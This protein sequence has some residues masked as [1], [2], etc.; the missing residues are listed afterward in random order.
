MFTST[1]EYSTQSASVQ[2]ISYLTVGKTCKEITQNLPYMF[3]VMS[4][5]NCCPI[6]RQIGHVL[7]MMSKD[8]Q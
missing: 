6:G 1:K 2:A 8:L 7:G 5:D 4:C 3:A